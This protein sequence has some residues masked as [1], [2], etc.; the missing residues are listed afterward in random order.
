MPIH[1]VALLGADGS[2]GRAVLSAL[3]AHKF[4]V[5]VLKRASST[6]PSPYP[7]SVT[8]T[9]LPDDFPHAETTT[10]LKDHDALIT[11]IKGSQTALLS[12]LADAAVAA[13]I[14]R[15]VPADFGSCDSGSSRAQELVPLFKHKTDLRAHLAELANAHETFS[16]TSLVCGHFF[17]ADLGFMHVDLENKRMDILDDGRVKASASTLRQVAEATARVLELEGEPRTRNCVLFVQSF[18]VSQL[19]VLAAY[20]RVTGCE[21]GVRWLESGVYE[22]DEV[23]KRDQGSKEAV[24]NL[25]WLLG[26]V[27][28]D[29]RGREEFAMGLLGLEEEGLDEVV[30]RIVKE[31]G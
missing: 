30:G 10:A 24:E 7:S 14:Q 8:V 3:V 25:V 9:H 31:Q 26:N 19:E 5:T 18:C 17:D 11:T 15:F 12:R 28:G 20:E 6:S 2:L 13:N 29:W 22:R 27:E 4:T 16:W 23:A 21:W 1:R